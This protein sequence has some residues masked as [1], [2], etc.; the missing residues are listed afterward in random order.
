MV[1]VLVGV[2]FIRAAQ[3]ATVRPCGGIFCGWGLW[4]AANFFSEEWF[5]A[6]CGYIGGAVGSDLA[7]AFLDHSTNPRAYVGAAFWGA[8]GGGVTGHW[9]MRF[10]P[11]RWLLGVLWDWVESA[12]YWLWYKFE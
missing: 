8:V 12:I 1:V 2:Q 3:G 9:M 10:G 6:Y 5:D 7:T 4:S 11:T